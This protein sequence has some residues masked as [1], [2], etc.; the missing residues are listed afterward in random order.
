MWRRVEEEEE[1]EEEE[2]EER[3]SLYR[4]GPSMVARLHSRRGG[5]G[6]FIQ[7]W[8]RAKRDS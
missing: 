3:R 4:I 6:D 1:K 8:L 7:N 5:G 2:E